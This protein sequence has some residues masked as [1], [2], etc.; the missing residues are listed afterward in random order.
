MYCLDLS[1]AP[2]E[3][4]SS[5]E[6]TAS[7]SSL[8]S[9]SRSSSCSSSSSSDEKM[10]RKGKGKLRLSK[11]KNKIKKARKHHK[12][13]DVRKRGK[14][15][16]KC[17]FYPLWSKFIFHLLVFN[18]WDLPFSRS[19]S[20]SLSLTR[21]VKS[22]ARSTN[23]CSILCSIFRRGRGGNPRVEPSYL[24]QKL[25]EK[26]TLWRYVTHPLM[27]TGTI[28]VYSHCSLAERKWTAS[29]ALAS[30]STATPPLPVAGFPVLCSP[31]NSETRQYGE[32]WR[33]LWRRCKA[34][35]FGSFRRKL[36]RTSKDLL[37]AF[38]EE[39]RCSCLFS[40]RLWQKFYISSVAYCVQRARG[41][42]VQFILG[43]L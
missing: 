23:V 14:T 15:L 35:M 1:K 43:D 38:A 30:D 42:N 36:Q 39:E 20:L 5:E 16:V 4:Q 41:G 29:I 17:W 21:E 28:H 7:C 6:D 37:T 19:F 8:S 10:K 11:T 22:E 13:T 3:E 25:I 9:M 34:S 2:R 27:Q 33:G 31:S 24:I 40:H 32:F 12:V 18:I 26:F